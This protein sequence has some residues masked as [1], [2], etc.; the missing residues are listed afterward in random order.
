MGNAL[1]EVI[2]IA[3]ETTITND[4]DGVV[5]FLEKIFGV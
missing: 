2:Q 4:E 3:K 5:Y 1:P